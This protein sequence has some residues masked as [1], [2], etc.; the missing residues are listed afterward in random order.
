ML[1]DRPIW[2]VETPKKQSR[3]T[4][5]Q[6]KKGKKGDDKSYFKIPFLLGRE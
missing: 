6:D 5:R 2:N 4:E 3:L 1:R